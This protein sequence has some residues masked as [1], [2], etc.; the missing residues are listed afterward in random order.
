MKL[1]T[2]LY[3]KLLKPLCRSYSRYILGDKQA[4][5]IYRSLCI[6]TFLNEHHYWPHFR[7][8]RTFSEK[9]WNRMFYVAKKTESKYLIPL[10]WSGGNAEDIPFDGLPEKFVIKA[11]H[12]CGYNI[13]VQ[14]KT[15]LD[16]AKTKKQ[17]STWLEENF[18]LDKFLGTAWAYKNI[19]PVIM[20]EQFL[21][22]NGQVPKDYKFFCYAGRAEFVQLSFDRFGDASERLLDRNF[23]PLDAWNGLKL[24]EGDIIKPNN[25]NEMLD[26]ADSLAL[27][28]DFIRIDLYSVGSQIYVGELTCYPAGGIARFVPQKYDYIFGEKWKIEIMVE[29]SR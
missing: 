12:G 8:P 27:G 13:I 26:L 5:M 3:T 17:L 21:N 20:I 23:R 6:P 2:V 16:K 15:Q 22:D 18:C 24:Y 25:Y 28:F 4:D 10:L 14:N 9:I 1:T 19:K 29:G 11:N 7:N